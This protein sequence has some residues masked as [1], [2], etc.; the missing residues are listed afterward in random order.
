MVQY[1]FSDDPPLDVDDGITGQLLTRQVHWMGALLEIKRLSVGTPSAGCL[2]RQYRRLAPAIS[3][4][5]LVLGGSWQR[6]CS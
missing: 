4:Y 2:L 5:W 6:Y 3:I 1:D